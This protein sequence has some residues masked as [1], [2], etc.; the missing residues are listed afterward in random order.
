[1]LQVPPLQV[2]QAEASFN[3][4]D[5]PP[6][7]KAERSF[8]TFGLPQLSQTTSASRPRR[9]RASNRFLHFSHWNS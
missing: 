4:L 3:R 6:I 5:P 2:E 8:L 1:V 7:P 9:T